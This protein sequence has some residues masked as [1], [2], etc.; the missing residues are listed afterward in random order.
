M[1]RIPSTTLSAQVRAYF[2]L[3]QDDLGQYAG[4]SRSMVVQ[5]ETRRCDY[6]PGSWLRLLPLVM[7]L[8]TG[9]GPGEEALEAAAAPDADLL[10]HHLR[11]C[12]HKAGLLRLTLEKLELPRQHAQRWQRVL[13]LLLADLPA[14]PATDDRYQQ[15]R[16][17]WLAYHTA[18][19]ADV[20]R[21]RPST[22][23]QQLALRLRLRL[24][25]TEATTLRQWLAEGEDAATV[26]Q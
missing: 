6:S 19:M 9:S 22:E 13:P 3:S 17:R 24:L 10:R 7:E 23:L 20:L 5:A 14:D 15:R 8:P 25:E 11:T 21:A 18:N 16:R 12:E 1:K 4:V 2:G 26:E